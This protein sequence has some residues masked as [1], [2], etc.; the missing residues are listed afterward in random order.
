MGTPQSTA[1]LQHGPADV[2]VRAA[3]WSRRIVGGVVLL[4]LALAPFVPG[5]TA[6]TLTVLVAGLGIVAGVPHGA[7]DHLL[8]CRLTGRSLVQ[9]TGVYAVVAGAAWCLITWAG[10]AAAVLVVVL[11]AVHFG[12]GELEVWRESTGWRPG[13]GVAVAAA[14][15]GTG[16]LL[17]PLAFS[18]DL[19]EAVATAMSPGLAATIASAPVRL[20]GVVAW[21]VAAVVAGVAAH[22]AGRR[23]VVLDLALIGALGT[24]LPPLAAFAVWF[25]GWHA[26]RHTGRLLADEPGC[27]ALLA[28][29]RGGSALLR[30]CRLAALPTLAAL[31]VLAALAGFARS[32]ADPG[33]AI[34]EALK[35][36]LALTVP[37][38]VVV[39]WF[40]RRDR[41][42]AHPTATASGAP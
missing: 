18:G 31:A 12:L 16:A 32:A 36:L 15:A 7:V 8:L 25:G 38:M 42:A 39:L 29:G 40:D 27:A 20:G 24:V 17:V 9:V 2:V 1:A 23:A 10:T 3:T 35:I 4:A 5:S 22:R 14:L 28:A 11:G 37:H 19:I 6:A 34:A 21:V 33:A 30:F 26:V 13:R 41:Q